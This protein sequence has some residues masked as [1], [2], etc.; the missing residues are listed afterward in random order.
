MYL[1][2]PKH[3][4]PREEELILLKDHHVIFKVF[5]PDG[6]QESWF[7]ENESETIFAEEFIRRRMHLGKITGYVMVC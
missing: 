6:R 1:K 2:L 5:Y 4:I 7:S 3:V